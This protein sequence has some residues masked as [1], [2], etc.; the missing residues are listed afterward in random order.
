MRQINSRVHYWVQHLP[1]K[2]L[3]D[4]EKQNEMS[5]LYEHVIDLSSLALYLGCVLLCEFVQ[6][7]A[8][9][10]SGIGFGLGEKLREGPESESKGG[11]GPKFRTRLGSK[12]SVEAGSKLKV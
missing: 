1:C 5:Y 6:I 8:G 9:T 12:S 10:G 4:Q 11:P 3:T 7:G 2:T